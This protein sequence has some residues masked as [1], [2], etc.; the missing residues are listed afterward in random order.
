MRSCA[1]SFSF[2]PIP[3]TSIPLNRCS[4]QSSPTSNNNGMISPCLSLM[5]LATTSPLT[6]LGVLSSHPS[7]LSN[8]GPQCNKTLQN[9]QC[10]ML[11]S[12]SVALSY[13]FPVF[14]LQFFSEYMSIHATDLPYLRSPHEEGVQS[15]VQSTHSALH[16][17]IISLI[18]SHHTL[19]PATLQTQQCPC[20]GHG[21][22][23]AQTAVHF[24]SPNPRF[25]PHP[26]SHRLPTSF[27][28]FPRD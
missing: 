3:W 23:H 21:R 27:P 11:L 24:G 22:R 4:S 6:W 2:P 15:F 17:I 13:L 26:T 8:R 18:T 28:H 7:M 19:H 12:C 14:R 5:P 20:D 10:S 25:A 1:N 16:P 9:M